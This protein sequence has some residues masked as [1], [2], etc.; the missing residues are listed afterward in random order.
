MEGTQ[1]GAEVPEAAMRLRARRRNIVVWR[2]TR[3]RGDR[4]SLTAPPRPAPT[5]RLQRL[6]RI[7]WLLTVIG[8]MRLACA[9]GRRW[10]PVLAGGALI[11]VAAT[12][13]GAVGGLAFLPGILFLYSAVLIEGRPEADR[14]RRFALERELAGYSTPAQRRDLEATLDRYPDGATHELREILARQSAARQ[15]NPSG[16]GGVPGLGRFPF[17]GGQ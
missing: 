17:T 12:L 7:G 6:L 2:S 15:A 8:L 16:T 1:S 5:R 9:L 13:R 10:P 14:K 3:A 4:Y 11:A